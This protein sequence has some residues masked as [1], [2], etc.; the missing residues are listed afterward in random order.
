MSGFAGVDIGTG[1]VRAVVL[2]D[3]GECLAEAHQE[4]ATVSVEERGLV[5]QD[6]SE[7][8]SAAAGC[9]RQCLRVCGPDQVRAVAVCGTSGTIVA[10]DKWGLPLRPALLYSDTRA[11]DAA[12]RLN[13]VAGEHAG[14]RFHSSSGL[15]KILWLVEEEPALTERT[16]VFAHSADAIT[17]R[18]TGR[19]G[20]TDWSHALKSGYDLTTCAWPGFLA[21]VPVPV[22]R[23]PHVVPP[24]SLLGCVTPAAAEAT[25]LASGTAVIAGMTDGC[26]SQVASGAVTPGAWSTSVGSTLVWKGVSASR[27]PEPGGIVYHHRLPGGLW[28]PGAASNTGAACLRVFPPDRLQ[29]LDRVAVGLAPTGVLVYPLLGRGERFPFLSPEA[30]GFAVG[31]AEAEAIRFTAL[32][33]G[34]AFIERLG[35]EVLEELGARI[36]PRIGS[37]GGGS[38]SR[39]W[40]QIRADILGREVYKPVQDGPAAGMAMLAAAGFL[41][42]NLPEV[43][44]SMVRIELDVAPR[45]DVQDQFATLYHHFKEE[46][47]RRGYLCRATAR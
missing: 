15:A 16:R 2:T 30:V 36:G 33:E 45:T 12:I 10:L 44:R 4:I 28:M 3:A 43:V 17:S 40:M 22:D 7:W 38:R 25:G 26:A 35:Y 31:A 41:G 47:A 46:C 27:L 18:L 13:A 21:R 5:E 9:L 20:L 19:V 8:W 14:Y 37:A 39:A 34:V 23:L 11:A 6:V 32:L 29:A 24:G 42:G 1:G